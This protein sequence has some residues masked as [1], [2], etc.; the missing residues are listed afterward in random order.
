LPCLAREIE[1]LADKVFAN[2][3]LEDIWEHHDMYD[4]LCEHAQGCRNEAVDRIAETFKDCIALKLWFA[5]SSQVTESIANELARG[6][7]IRIAWSK[8]G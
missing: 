2:A 7:G 3:Y 5:G 6:M 4:Y 1:R 8:S